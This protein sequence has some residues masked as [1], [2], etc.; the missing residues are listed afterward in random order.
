MSQGYYRFPTIFQERVV[1]VSE[2]DLWQVPASGGRAERLTAGRGL[3]TYPFFSPDGQWLAYIGREEGQEEVYLMPS[4]GGF[5]RRLTFIGDWRSRVAG[6]TPQGEVVFCCNH[7]QPIFRWQELWAVHPDGGAPRPLH[8]GPARAIAFG[9]EGDRVL[10][11]STDDPRHW[12]RDRGGTVGTLWIAGK[13]SDDFH[14]LIHLD[15]DLGSPMWLDGR[16]YFLSDHEGLSS[17]Y[18]CLPDGSDLR[19]HSSDSE[20]YAY[21]ASTDGR[22]IVYH[23]GAELYLF[24]PA[25]GSP[26]R[27]EVEFPGP[28]I[29]HARCFVSALEHLESWR[30]SPSG[31]RTVITSRGRLFSFRNWDGAVLQHGEKDGVRYRL[32]RFLPDGQRLLAVSDQSG[33]DGFIIFPADGSAAPQLLPQLDIGR[34]TEIHPN[35]KKELVAF[36]N[37]RNELF[38]LDLTSSKL[39]LID[40]SEQRSC[41]LDRWSEARGAMFD[42]SPNGEW[43][44]FTRPVSLYHSQICLWQASSGVIHPLTEG[45]FKDESPSFD[46]QGNYLYFISYRGFTPYADNQV[47]GAGFPKGMKLF[48]VPLRKE[49]FSPFAPDA[50]PVPTAQEFRID[51]DSLGQRLLALPLEEG[52]YGR[53]FGL[54]DSKL[55]F[56]SYPLEGLANNDWESLPI[57]PGNLCLFDLAGKNLKV[58]ASGVFDFHVSQDRRALI[59]RQGARLRVIDF[60]AGF[61]PSSGEASGPHSGWIDLERVKLGIQPALEW[62]QMFNEAWRLERDFYWTAGMSGV[63]WPAVRQ[64]YLPLVERVASRAELSALIWEMQSELGIGH[65]YEDGGD[66]RKPPEYRQGSL[67][68]DCEYDEAATGWRIA[69]LVRGDSWDEKGTSPL[70]APGLEIA[71]GDLLMAVNGQALSRSF[72][73]AAA[74]VNLAGSPVALTFKSARTQA[75]FQ[76]TIQTL[77]DELPSRYREWVAANRIRVHAASGGRLGYLHIPDMETLGMAEFQ[78]GLLEELEAP[79]LLVDVRYNTGGYFSPLMLEKLARRRLGFVQRR[80]AKA[81]DSY[82][83]FAPPPVLVGLINEYTGS[84]GDMFS[85]GFKRLGL[86]PLVGK[87]TWGGIVGISPRNPLVDGTVT[88]QP[89]IAFGFPDV[90]WGIENHGVAPEL[91]VENLPQ[92]YTRGF[93]AQL[94]RAI[95]EALRLLEMQPGLTLPPQPPDRAWP[96]K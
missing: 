5:S 54:A 55:A 38:M 58:L 13:K 34:V 23:A 45:G 72:S 9:S 70:A 95:Q 14:A 26:H 74:L 88:T 30:L 49:M 51:L 89:E 40:R 11:R 59:L 91:E 60:R 29:Q 21:N 1:F 87:R 27:I 57:P 18:S 84:D 68:A 73:P 77:K 41:R 69:H 62:R 52:Q 56:T 7:R 17:L 46:P 42:W 3:C 94:E 36:S 10:G 47:F 65:A 20:Y 22:R 43:L 16:V 61:D 96:R 53:V 33:E 66:H 31:E 82:P 63:D 44:A 28:R 37:Q 12:K 39:T 85:A 15:G 83:P 78:R 48:L 64:R 71:E 50:Q 80:W 90:G 67:G 2:D 25:Q 8:L 75:V 6:W 4:S 79:G 92:D 86:G 19:R 76:V 81:L 93:D 35:P 24:D 32:A